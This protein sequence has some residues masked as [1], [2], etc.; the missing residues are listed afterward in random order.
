MSQKP[1]GLGRM[2]IT[3]YIH[4]KHNIEPVHLI[5]CF[6]SNPYN[7]WG[8]PMKFYNDK[9]IIK[10]S[11]LNSISDINDSILVQKITNLVVVRKID[12]KNYECLQT[13]N[14]Y[15]FTLVKKSMPDWIE[16]INSYYKGM[17]NSEIFLIYSQT[18]I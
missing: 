12:L 15:H 7:P 8:L 18:K 3:K 1:G 17:D 9:N 4:E 14:K 16:K 11:Q 13:L 6:Y 2:E 5:T 10:T